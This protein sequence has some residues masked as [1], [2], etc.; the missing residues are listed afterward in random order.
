MDAAYLLFL[1]DQLRRVFDGK[2]WHGPSLR[3]LLSDM[4]PMQAAAHPVAGA[5]SIWELV[6]HIEVW[7]KIALDA[8]QGSPMP[9]NLPAELDWPKPYDIGPQAW[10][11]ALLRLS[12]TKE[13]LGRAI[14]GFSPERL[15][16]IVPGRKYDFH[17]LLTGITQHSL[18]HAGQIALLKKAAQA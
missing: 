12:E 1:A 4:A 9:Q 14:E 16:E 3:E 13:Q 17:F 18:Y 10:N 7:A 5:H 8:V 11:A 6:L 2:A 15:Q